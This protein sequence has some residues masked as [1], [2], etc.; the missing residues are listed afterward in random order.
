[1]NLTTIGTKRVFPSIRKVYS[2]KVITE[3]HHLK[4]TVLNDI[5][6]DIF[7][8]SNLASSRSSSTI[9]ISSK[10]LPK[11]R[12]R[13]NIYEHN[14]QQHQDKKEIPNWPTIVSMLIVPAMFVAWGTSDWFFGNKMKGYNEAL[15]KKF[16][17]THQ[18]LHENNDDDYLTV[19]ENKPILFSCVIRRNTGF[20]HCLSSVQLG[21]VVEVLEEGVGPD[22]AYNLCRLPTKLSTESKSLSTDTYGWFPIRWLQKLE[23]YEAMVQEQDREIY[24]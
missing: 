22:R 7:R 11:R 2:Y 9:S 5:S 1:M 6:C 16:V 12:R 14:Q 19:L 18:Y 3:S 20:T 15:R 24:K 13:K 4:T 23:H 21:D 17:A 10:N 8:G